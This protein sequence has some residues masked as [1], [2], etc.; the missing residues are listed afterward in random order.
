MSLND[1]VGIACLAHSV[2]EVEKAKQEG[3]EPDPVSVAYIW[4]IVLL[5]IFVMGVNQES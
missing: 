3:R 4:L 1:I 2:Q 5:F